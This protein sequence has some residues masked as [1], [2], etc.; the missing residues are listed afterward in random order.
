[1]RLMRHASSLTFHV[2]RVT[3]RVYNWLVRSELHVAAPPAKP[4]IIYDGDCNFCLRWIRRWQQATGDRVAY[5]PY[6]DSRVAAALPELPRQQLESAVH[7]VQADG[8][9]YSGAEAALRAVACN[10]SHKL[11]LDWYERSPT[12]ANLAEQAY[13]FIA[14]HRRLFSTLTRLGW[15]RDAGPPS[16]YWVRWLFLRALGVIYL[17]A[18]ISLWVQI[19]GLVGANGI[20]PAKLTMQ[21]LQSQVESQK[22]GLERYHLAPTFCWL[23]SSDFF[24]KLQCIAGTMLAFW[25]IVGL[26]PAPS[27]FLLWLIYLS[28]STVCRE[29]LGF[30]WDILLLE[31]SFLA[32]FFAPLQWLP[33]FSRGAQKSIP[34]AECQQANGLLSPA[35]PSTRLRDA[36]AQQDGKERAHPASSNEGRWLIWPDLS[37][38]APPSR[39]VLWVLRGLLFLLMFES[40]RVK[41]LSHD[42]LWRNLTA[43]TVH[44]QTQPLPTWIGWYTHQLPLWTQRTSTA[45]MFGIELVLPFFIFGPRRLRLF[46]GVIFVAF[47]T[48]ILLTGNYCFFNLLTIVLCLALMDD[49]ALKK[50]V[51]RRW[52]FSSQG[53]TSGEFER[54]LLP[55][56][57]YGEQAGPLPRREGEPSAMQEAVAESQQHVAADPVPCPA[58]TARGSESAPTHVGFYEKRRL[59]WPGVITVPLAFLFCIISLMQLCR[60]FGARI[61]WPQRLVRLQVWLYPLRT[62]NSYGLFAVMTPSRPEIIIEGSSDGVTWLEYEFKYKPGDVRRRPRFVEPHQPRL[63]WQMWFAALGTYRDNPWF[64]NFCIRLLQGSPEVLNLLAHN[65][66]PDA[67]PRYI[68]AVTYDYR[69][70][71]FAQRR[72]TGAWWQREPQG[73]YLPPISLRNV[74]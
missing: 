36:T 4:L 33:R 48:L 41:L 57:H 20:L 16:H 25:V 51:P 29:F 40:G 9:V 67:P 11:W 1:M 58:L 22:M 63:D 27:L 12:V 74:Q 15:G 52:R 6:Q 53:E 66:F 69:F 14:G 34:E 61:E 30:Q 42:P 64:V 70:T 65:P 13:R 28:L 21:V 35:L 23:D 59:G 46:A 62:F 32:I 2:S 7:F 54:A 8:A 19:I 55:H 47:Q 43:L 60:T 5:L 72:I 68:R 3:I 37:R 39:I 45:I 73:I 26:A 18:F 24:L 44:Y 50:I 10:R 31:T 38:E 17:V 71:T 49:A 56:P